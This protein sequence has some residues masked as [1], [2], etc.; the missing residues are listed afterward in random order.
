LYVFGAGG[1]G[2]VVA[3]VAIRA[4]WRVLALLD[5]NP[6]LADDT[7][8]GLPVIRGR[9]RVE[10]LLRSEDLVVFAIGN[11]AARMRLQRELERRGIRAQTVISPQAIVSDWASVGNGTVIMPGAIVN[12]GAVIGDGAIL[13]T[14]AVVEHDCEVADFAHV[15]P[16]SSL[17]GAA[18]IGTLS[19]VGIGSSVLP[20]VRIGARTIL[21]AGSV[22]TCDLP[23]DVV[24][25]G[26]PARIRRRL[27]YTDPVDIE[28]SY[29]KFSAA[30][31][32]T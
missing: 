10:N 2:K 31:T 4:G 13:N 7:V 29:K 32:R 8:W 30:E 17:G 6:K 3:D 27:S 14:A 18:K 24:A 28:H 25:Y 22:A 1:H 23:D 21:G 26:V 12:A 11:N 16:N 9:D 5:D 15:S 19:Q 20:Q